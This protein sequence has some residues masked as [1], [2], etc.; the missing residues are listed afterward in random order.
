MVN[1]GLKILMGFN[2]LAGL[3]FIG[4]GLGPGQTAA[5]S[6]AVVVIFIVWGFM[7]LGLAWALWAHHRFARI[8]TFILYGFIGLATLFSLAG[9]F[10]D[11]QSQI[12]QY[13]LVYGLVYVMWFALDLAPIVF[14]LR[15]DV[16][17]YLSTPNDS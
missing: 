11:A 15:A 2:V 5:R 3:Y 8:G 17:E 13:P 12:F 6:S 7:F 1:I 16:K 9:E 10:Q 14:M 4:M